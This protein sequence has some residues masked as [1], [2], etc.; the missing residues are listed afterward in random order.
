MKK[1][2]TS[3]VLAALLSVLMVAS[4]SPTIAKAKTTDSQPSSPVIARSYISEVLDTYKSFTCDAFIVPKYDTV[5]K[6]LTYR[7]NYW[8][9][10]DRVISYY[11]GWYNAVSGKIAQHKLYYATK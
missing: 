5:Y 7:N 10:E 11:S 3:L 4:Y 1:L 9:T 8:V 2:L 6:R